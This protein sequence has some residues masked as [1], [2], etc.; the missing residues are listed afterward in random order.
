MGDL[1][2]TI[3]QGDPDRAR[4]ESALQKAGDGVGRDALDPI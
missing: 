4:P 3:G 2:A 1:I